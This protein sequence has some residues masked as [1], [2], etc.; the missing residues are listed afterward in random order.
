MEKD[1]VKRLL[2][3][4]DLPQDVQERL[5]GAEYENEEAVKEAILAEAK[6]GGD[7][8]KPEPVVYLAEAEIKTLLEASRLPRQAQGRLAEGQYLD[9]EALKTVVET[10]RAYIKELTG[11]GKPFAQGESASTD[12]TMTEAEYDEA[13]DDIRR[14]HG[15]HVQEV[16]N[17]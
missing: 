7:K 2:S 4:S 6:D 13:Y 17:A 14:R 10:E 3:E 15:L 16:N 12:A 9:V 1:Q 11:S 5:A 8:P